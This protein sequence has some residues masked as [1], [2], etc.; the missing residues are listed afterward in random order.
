MKYFTLFLS[1]LCWSLSAQITIV[2]VY[3]S[4][5]RT[6][7]RDYGN[8]AIEVLLT[9][10]KLVQQGRLQEA[11]LEYNTA[12]KMWPSW[13][14]IYLKRANAKLRMG[15]TTEAE[16][17]MDR[18]YSLSSNSVVLFSVDNPAQKMR[19]L[20][21]LQAHK[22]TGHPANQIYQLQLAGETFRVDYLLDELETSGQLPDTEIALLRGNQRFLQENHSEAIAY[23]DWA[24]SRGATPE[25][26]YN[27]GLARILMLNY[28]DGCADLREAAKMNYA[29]AITQAADLCVF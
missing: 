28:P 26:L 15:R 25:L 10:D 20:A 9:G 21:S 5:E 14:P 3:T 29:P 23:Y 18:A 2:D 1:L 4:N 16:E 6:D 13:A 8:G 17:D 22:Q 7:Q 19:I 11:V 27:R 12:V 24:I